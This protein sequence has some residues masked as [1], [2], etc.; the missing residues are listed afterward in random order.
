MRKLATT[1][2][3]MRQIEV[4][5]NSNEMEEIEAAK[6]T[7]MKIST[8]EIEYV[9]SKY[10]ENTLESSSVLNKKM[11]T[12]MYNLNRDDILLIEPISTLH[13]IYDFKQDCIL[14]L[15]EE[16]IY[17]YNPLKEASFKTFVSLKIRG[18]MQRNFQ[19]KYRTI[20]I[21]TNLMKNYSRDIKK[22]EYKNLSEERKE[23]LSKIKPL[24]LNP[25]EGNFI[26]KENEWEVENDWKIKERERERIE[27][28]KDIFNNLLSKQEYKYLL[29]SIDEKF[30]NKEIAEIQGVTPQYVSKV[31]INAKKKIK[32]SKEL[33]RMWL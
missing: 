8:K 18:F 21:A 16:I 6:E 19:S 29:L 15:F 1:E 17:K 10:A 33:E 23:H 9:I 32:N 5:K 30:S 12:Q 13:P 27:K 25:Y 11:L 7:I 4:I 26:H 24:L 28:L 31:I 22:E 3:V 2:E 20:A 14:Y